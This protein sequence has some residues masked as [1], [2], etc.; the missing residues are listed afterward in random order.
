MKVFMLVG[1]DRGDKSPSIL[2]MLPG[3]AG[4]GSGEE[5]KDA[6]SCNYVEPLLSI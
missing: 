4:P 1:S 6:E 3:I 5:D 2:I